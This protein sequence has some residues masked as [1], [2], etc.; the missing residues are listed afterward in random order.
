MTPLNMESNK[1]LLFEQVIF[2]KLQKAEQEAQ[3][4]EKRFT[5]AE[6]YSAMMESIQNKA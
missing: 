4:T 6:V 3:S 5:P 2:D 1:S